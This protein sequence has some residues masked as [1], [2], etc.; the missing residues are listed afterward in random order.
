MT[1]KEKEFLCNLINNH[2]SPFKAEPLSDFRVKVTHP[3][4]WEKIYKCL[5][6]PNYIQQIYDDWKWSKVPECDCGCCE[7]NHLKNCPLTDPECPVLKVKC[8]CGD[9]FLKDK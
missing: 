4:G 8:I 6:S 1:Q 9:K 5:G 3:D 7:H 2:Q